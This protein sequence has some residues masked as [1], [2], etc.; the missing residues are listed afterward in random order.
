MRKSIFLIVV[1]LIVCLSSLLAVSATKTDEPAAWAANAVT[2]LDTYQLIPEELFSDYRVPIKRDEFAAILIGVYNEACQNY[3]NFPNEIN[4]FTDMA[5]SKYSIEVKKA[6]VMGI[7]NGTSATTFSPGNNITREDT[8]TLT[9]RF[10]KLS[11]RS[12]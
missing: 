1:I 9:Y 4:P 8:A 11:L 5:F 7:I 6:N 12:P 2:Y 3:Y 10:I